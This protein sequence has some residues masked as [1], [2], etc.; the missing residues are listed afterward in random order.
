MN[1]LEPVKPISRK[2]Y[3]HEL[4]LDKINDLVWDNSQ[5]EL[6]NQS[7]RQMPHT[8]WVHVWMNLHHG[9]FMTVD[10]YLEDTIKS[11]LEFTK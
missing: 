2:I 10:K 5:N 4:G 8:L 3:E 11:Q 9:V 6:F 1:E 7:R